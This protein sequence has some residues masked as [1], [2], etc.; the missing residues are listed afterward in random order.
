MDG[1][2]H[3]HRGLG[4]PNNGAQSV[5][6]NFT[7]RCDT[8]RLTYVLGVGQALKVRSENHL[9]NLVQTSLWTHLY[10]LKFILVSSLACP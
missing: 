4:R 2:L 1:I 10:G 7:A 8:V 3:L 5:N 9:V 6:E